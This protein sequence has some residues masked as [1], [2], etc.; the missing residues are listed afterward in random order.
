M[1]ATIYRVGEETY[2]TIANQM[3][4]RSEP[5]LGGMLL[6]QEPEIGI[7]QN[8][9]GGDGC[10]VCSI[11]CRGRI[12]FLSYNCLSHSAVDPVG[13][14][15]QVGLDDLSRSQGHGGCRRVDVHHATA[16]PDGDVG[17]H[18]VDEN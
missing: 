3:S 1:S 14:Y 11:P 8:E 9:V 18:Q 13:S 16:K 15:D 5:N 2:E 17:G 6:D 10:A 7:S 12:V 4:S